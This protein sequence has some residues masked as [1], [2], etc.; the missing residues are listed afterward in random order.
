MGDHYANKKNI[1]A[2]FMS[3]MVLY[4]QQETDITQAIFISYSC[5]LNKLPNN[6]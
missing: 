3:C 5:K 1:V 4:Q 2:S 6:N